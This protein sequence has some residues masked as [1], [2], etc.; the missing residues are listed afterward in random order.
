MD[1]PL[2]AQLP[3]WKIPLLADIPSVGTILPD[4]DLWFYISAQ[5]VKIAGIR[6]L[7]ALVVPAR[8]G[9]TRDRRHQVAP[10]SDAP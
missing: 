1:V 3:A 6:S 2:P 8:G 4:K 9:L 10:S 7:C 5:G